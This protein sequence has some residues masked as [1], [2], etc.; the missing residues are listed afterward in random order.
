MNTSFIMSTPQKTDHV[1]TASTANHD[2]SENATR[3]Q[4]DIDKM[5]RLLQKHCTHS[6]R[7][8]NNVYVFHT[9]SIAEVMEKVQKD[10]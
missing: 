2:R 4:C 3:Q 5:L 8:P 9:D 6:E 1:N 10:M 7:L